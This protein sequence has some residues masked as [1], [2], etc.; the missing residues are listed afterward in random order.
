MRPKRGASRRIRRAS[1]WG[2]SRRL[3]TMLASRCGGACRKSRAPRQRG[4]ARM[5]LRR[6]SAKRRTW[7]T[8][9]TGWRLLVGGSGDRFRG[10]RSGFGRARGRR[11][12]WTWS[13]G[14]WII[15]SGD[16]AV[17]REGLPARCLVSCFWLVEVAPATLACFRWRRQLC[18]NLCDGHFLR[19][20]LVRVHRLRLL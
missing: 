12:C 14:D 11:W 7:R 3:W 2:R 10:L 18:W 20:R 17:R 5:L 15:L 13:L 4:S 8:W 9:G 6:G 19:S 16:F 1:G